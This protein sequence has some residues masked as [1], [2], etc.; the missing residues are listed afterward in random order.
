MKKI[1]FFI[2]VLQSFVSLGQKIS[3]KHEMLQLRPYCG[4]ARPTK[5][6]EEQGRTSQPYA[7]LTLIYKSDK[8]KIDSV[9]TDGKGFL[10]ANLKPGTYKF[11]EPWKY[12]K[13]T[14]DGSPFSSYNKTCI[15]GEWKKEDLKITVAAKGNPI[16]KNNI[17]V[18]KC[19]WDNDC[20]LQKHM[21]E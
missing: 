15:E 19:F 5:E 21:P 1:I 17:T 11:F 10:I 8:G 14:P 16:I 12:Y 13:K 3:I 2:A 18:A 7:N 4:G 6:M 20:L 9:K